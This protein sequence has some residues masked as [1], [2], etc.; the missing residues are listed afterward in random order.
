MGKRKVSACEFCEDDRV[1]VVGAVEKLQMPS[2]QGQ[3]GER[4]T[5]VDSSVGLV[6]SAKGEELPGRSGRVDLVVGGDRKGGG[7]VLLL[8]RQSDN[9]HLERAT[10]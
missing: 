9:H 8:E 2:V 5:Y 10:V 6:V 7:A 4:D 3:R 1:T